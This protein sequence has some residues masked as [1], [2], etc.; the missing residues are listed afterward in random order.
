[1]SVQ[2]IEKDGRPEW[3]VVPYDEYLRMAEALEDRED[4]QAIE[5]A[6]GEETIP[7]A[8]IKRLLDENPIRVWREY[9]GLTMAALAEHCGVS[10]P[11]ISQIE[12]GQR[13]PSVRLLK[14]MAEALEVDMDDLVP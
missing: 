11:A 3:A 1:M 10:V 7:H 9:R 12:S 5:A 6:Q 14:A 2:I 8:I 4:I 13:K